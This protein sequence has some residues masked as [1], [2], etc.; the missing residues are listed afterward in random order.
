MNVRIP[1]SV[2]ALSAWLGR[3]GRAVERLQSRLPRAE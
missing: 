3:A 2:D 1:R